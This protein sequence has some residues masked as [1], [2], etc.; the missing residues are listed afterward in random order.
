PVSSE[1][2]RFRFPGYTT[3][4]R[5]LALGPHPI[6]IVRMIDRCP[7]VIRLKVF[8]GKTKILTQA[9]VHVKGDPILSHNQNVMWNDIDELLQLSFTLSERG[10]GPLTF[11]DVLHGPDKLVL[12]AFIS[13]GMCHNVDIFD[14]AIRHQ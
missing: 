3:R 11:G 6:Q 7:E 10:F 4:H 8:Q 1:Y 9:L 13:R 5:I 14:G 2:S 12:V